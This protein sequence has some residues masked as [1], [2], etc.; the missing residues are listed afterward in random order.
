MAS[1]DDT[2]NTVGLHSIPDVPTWKSFSVPTQLQQFP[3]NISLIKV[4]RELGRVNHG[5]IFEISFEAFDAQV[6]H[7]RLS[8]RFRISIQDVER[9]CDPF[10]RECQAYSRIGENHGISVRCYGS[11]TFPTG[12]KV[13]SRSIKGVPLRGL[14][15]ELIPD[16]D[17]PF[18]LQQVSKAVAGFKTLMEIGIVMFGNKLD[19]YVGGRI[20][21]LSESYTAPNYIPIILGRDFSVPVA[22]FNRMIE[23]AQKRKSRDDPDEEA[24]FSASP[25][26]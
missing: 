16:S 24:A 12:H 7:K 2:S 25:V 4:I 10:Q 26:V 8:S 19:N 6:V 11:I 14:V 3:Y 22:Q 18:T 13:F 1:S 17:L 9:F 20:R 15:K 21:D 5:L 23:N